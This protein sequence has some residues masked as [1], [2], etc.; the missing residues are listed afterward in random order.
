VWA[1]AAWA[2][3]LAVTDDPSLADEADLVVC[4]PDGVAPYAGHAG[5]VPV[6]GLSLRPL[7]GR[8]TDPLPAGVT[9][10]GAVVLGQPDAFA[11]YDPPEGDDPAYRDAT[12][13]T[14]QQALLADAAGSELV[15]DGGRLLTDVAPTT[16]AG[17]ATLLVPL[18]RG[19]G[20]V[21][22]RHADPASWPARAEQE[23]TT[24]ELRA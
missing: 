19:G 4:G 6:L 18:L 21:W 9:D 24:A 10:Y 23:R 7:G 5:R 20:T 15:G 1:G 12:G 13:T 17:L 16:R 3:G 22:V 8:F 11:P 14:T 2:L